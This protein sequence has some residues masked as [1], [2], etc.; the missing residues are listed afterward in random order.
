MSS[1]LDIVDERTYCLLLNFKQKKLHLFTAFS[2]QNV[3]GWNLFDMQI[4]IWPH[5]SLLGRLIG[6]FFI[7]NSN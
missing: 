5:Y 4:P 2:Y 7:V 1:V 3:P 6:L